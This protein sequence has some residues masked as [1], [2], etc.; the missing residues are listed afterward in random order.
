MVIEMIDGE[1]PYLTETPLRAL[2]LI[3]STGKPSVREQSRL[4]QCP[5]LRSFLDKCLDVDSEK[6]SSAREAL[7]MPFL[8]CA[9]D[10]KTLKLNIEAIQA[11]RDQ[12]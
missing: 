2:F 11:K 6:R 12:E 8:Q 9:E 5:D 7:G 1:P 3:A 4:D 10:L